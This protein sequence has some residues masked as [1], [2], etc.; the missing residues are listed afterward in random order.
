MSRNH[1]H[2]AIGYPN[3]ENVISGM[4][5]SSNV[6]IEIDLQKAIWDEI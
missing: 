5:S 4:R 3:D 6:F 2:L 1:I